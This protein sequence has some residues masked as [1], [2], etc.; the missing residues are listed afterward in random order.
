MGLDRSLIGNQSSNDNLVVMK[1]CLDAARH[2]DTA[3]C[4]ILIPRL[5]AEHGVEILRRNTPQYF[6][7]LLV[8]RYGAFYGVTIGTKAAHLHSL[9]I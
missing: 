6:C 2:S 8:L 3:T 9:A 7:I 1:T 4:H 5:D